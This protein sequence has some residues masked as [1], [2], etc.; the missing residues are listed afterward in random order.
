M[1]TCMFLY[2]YVHFNHESTKICMF[3]Y[4]YIIYLV[5]TFTPIASS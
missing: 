3:P 2:F 1:K 4:M 5:P